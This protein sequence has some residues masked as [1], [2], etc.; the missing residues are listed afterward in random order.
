VARWII[1]D[2]FG[3]LFHVSIEIAYMVYSPLGVSQLLTP[4]VHKEYFGYLQQEV[5]KCR[6]LLETSLRYDPKQ[7]LVQAI[8]QRQR[9]S[10]YLSLKVASLASLSLSLAKPDTP[11]H[12]TSSP[13]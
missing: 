12:L 10:F 6:F 3:V 9:P 11:P 8:R 7:H 2:I 4:L 13:S 5:V 1:Q